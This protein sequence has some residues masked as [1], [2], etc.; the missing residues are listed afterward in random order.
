MHPSV[1]NYLPSSYP[2]IYPSDFVNLSNSHPVYIITLEY[3]N[4]LGDE[5]P[6]DPFEYIDTDGDTIGNNL[7]KDDDNDGYEDSNDSFELDPNEWS[8]LDG[9]N[10][11]DNFDLFDN[12]PLEW[13]DSDGDSVGDN[14]DGCIFEPGLNS[15][16]VD[17][18]HLLAI[19]NI[20]GCIPDPNL[21]IVEEEEPE[22]PEFSSIDFLDLDNDGEINLLD[23]DDDGDKIP[24]SQ[25]S[26]PYDPTRPFDQDVYL[27]ITITSI[28]LIFMLFRLV[29]W[30]K[31]KIAKFRSKRIH[32]E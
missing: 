4:L 20:I 24:D 22:I 19:G 2:L 10:K 26:H 27:L 16:Y 29:N 7:D 32:L 13:M 17:I 9:D 30:Q 14:S 31:T 23:I 15:S 28:F 8:D 25:D 6:L 3:C 21:N 11:G 18:T 12:D 5:F 1:L